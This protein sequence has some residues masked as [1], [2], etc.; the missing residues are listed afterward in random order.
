MADLGLPQL[1]SEDK[2]S[3]DAP[4]SE[5]ELK[6]AL[7]HMNHNKSPGAD[8]LPQNITNNSGPTWPLI[9]VKAWTTPS[10]LEA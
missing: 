6:N 10:L 9:F 2:N 5:E 3:L 4:L 7:S 1:S 8:G